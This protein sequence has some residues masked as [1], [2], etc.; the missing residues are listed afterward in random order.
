MKDTELKLVI[1]L[2]KNSH[3]SDRE[4]ARAIGTSQ[5]TLSR[6]REKLEKQGMIKEYTIIPDYPQ[7]GFTLMS[8]TFT[9]MKG[10][11]SKG[12]LDD[13]KKRVRNT[14]SEHPSALILGNT[15]MG[16]NADYVTIA[17]HRDYSEYSKFMTD[18]KEFPG[19]NIDET[20]SFIVDLDE[21]DQAQPLSFHHLAGYL[22]KTKENSHT[23]R[24]GARY[25]KK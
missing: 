6:T 11:F 19:V 25:D 18:I 14:I 4:L 12:I 21:K 13:L 20:K 3:R 16:C 7:L 2:L 10:S 9:K 17:F 15:G 24:K 8:I 22:A 1:E 5:P 23:E